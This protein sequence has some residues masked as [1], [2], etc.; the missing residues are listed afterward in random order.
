MNNQVHYKIHD[1]VNVL[2]RQSDEEIQVHML[3]TRMDDN[4]VVVHVEV[5]NVMKLFLSDE[6]LT[7][8]MKMLD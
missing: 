8:D 4:D 7:M 2:D 6:M 1:Y 3:H 5:T